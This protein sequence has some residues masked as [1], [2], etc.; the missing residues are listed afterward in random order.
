MFKRNN[1]IIVQCWFINF[2]ISATFT[3]PV[4]GRIIF[5]QEADEPLSDTMVSL[6]FAI[7]WLSC[8]QKDPTSVF[9]YQNTILALQIFHLP[10][11]GPGLCRGAGLHRR[12]QERQWLTCMARSQWNSW[13]GLLQLDR[14]MPIRWWTFQPVQNQQRRWVSRSNPRITPGL[15]SW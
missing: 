10:T 9:V 14:T 3:Y 5:R 6:S 1:E 12:K 7:W 4:G 11:F 2:I 15:G 8:C 13:Q